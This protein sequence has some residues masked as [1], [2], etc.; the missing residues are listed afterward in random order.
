M[1]ERF[2]GGCGGEGQCRTAVS[3]K[4]GKMRDEGWGRGCKALRTGIGSCNHVRSLQERV[5]CCHCDTSVIVVFQRLE[6][7]KNTVKEPHLLK[8]QPLKIY[9]YRFRR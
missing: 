5:A 4:R 8:P 7:C 2:A 3:S 1:A 9:V 6:G